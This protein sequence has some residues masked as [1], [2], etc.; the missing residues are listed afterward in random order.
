MFELDVFLRFSLSLNQP[1]TLFNTPLALS[2]TFPAKSDTPSTIPF[3]ASLIPFTA[4]LAN[5]P[6][7][8]TVPPTKSLT[9]P[10][11]L[12]T[13][14]PIPDT[15][16]LIFSP[17]APSA[18][19]TTSPTLPAKSNSFW[20][21][22]IIFS[23]TLNIGCSTLSKTLNAGTNTDCKTLP[24]VSINGA[25]ILKILPK[26][27]SCLIIGASIISTIGSNISTN[28]IKIFTIISSIGCKAVIRTSTISII[29]SNSLTNVSI[30]FPNNSLNF[31]LFIRAITTIATSAPIPRVA[32]L[33]PI[34]AIVPAAPTAFNAILTPLIKGP[35]LPTI[36]KIGPIAA[37]TATNVTINFLFPSLRL[38]HQDII[39]LTIGINLSLI[40]F[41][42]LVI[43]GTKATASSTERLFAA[44]FKFLSEFSNSPVTSVCSVVIKP[45]SLAFCLSSSIASLSKLSIG[46]NSEPTL[47][48]KSLLASASLNDSSSTFASAFLIISNASL[49]SLPSNSSIE[50]PSAWK[51]PA[52]DFTS[53]KAILPKILLTLPNTSS[54]TL[55]SVPAILA[56]W[57]HSCKASTDIPI[58]FAVELSSLAVF[59]PF[60]AS[61]VKAATAPKIGIVN[62]LVS[63][64]PT[65]AKLSNLTLP[66]SLILSLVLVSS[67]F[68]LFIS[69][70]LYD[71][72]LWIF[73]NSASDTVPNFKP[74]LAFSNAWFCLSSLVFVLASISFNWPC[75]F[76]Q[77]STLEL[78]Y[79]RLV[80]MARRSLCCSFKSLLIA[81][82][83]LSRSLPSKD[84]LILIPLIVSAI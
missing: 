1:P 13:K 71:T 68:N 32:A 64:P 31:S 44:V 63:V 12:P 27:S 20:K 4:P 83:S 57:F 3:V 74:C 35:T 56:T 65:L 72:F 70:S 51:I 59:A 40:I 39:L 41:T 25:I 16:P 67:L 34:P 52:N 81:F 80:L 37:A 17:T 79:L 45:R 42:T 28:F 11:T 55:V 22:P 23:N 77:S 54:K 76:L 15:T 62:P 60:L 24:T 26:N 18:P 19:P 5:S 38:V 47:S 75:F 43:A 48:P 30:S 78:S 69:A 7:L 14:S 8:P 9:L 66:K 10:V 61:A 29:G 21:N 36:D 82:I 50:I 49:V 6:I 33:I 2:L 53:P 84:N 46:N 73:L 58:L